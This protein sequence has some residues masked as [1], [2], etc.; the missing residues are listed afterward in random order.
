MQFA[1]R[2]YFNSFFLSAQTDCSIYKKNVESVLFLL[3]VSLSFLLFAPVLEIRDSG[4]FLSCLD[5]FLYYSTTYFYFNIIF[6][7]TLEVASHVSTLFLELILVYVGKLTL[8]CLILELEAVWLFS[9]MIVSA[10]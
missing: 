10:A 2:V 8:R 6:W 7:K 5:T 1:R 4:Q 3:C 9:T